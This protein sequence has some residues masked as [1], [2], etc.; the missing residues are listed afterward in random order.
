M[1][2]HWLLMLLACL[3]PIL[4][5]FLLPLFG[6]TTDFTFFLFLVI[7]FIAHLF[8]MRGHSHSRS[9]NH[10]YESQDKNDNQIKRSHH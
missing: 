2:N 3:A 7:F 9:G 10:R 4:L 8:M 5:I 6:V 1:R